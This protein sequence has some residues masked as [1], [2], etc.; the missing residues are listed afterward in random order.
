M[1]NLVTLETAFS[2]LK[3]KDK[4]LAAEISYVL[5]VK[6]H[7]NGEAKKSQF[8]A[9]ECV[10]MFDELDPE[11]KTLEDAASH[12]NVVDGVVLPEF[13]HAKVV[14]ERFQKMGISY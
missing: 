3:E 9:A 4:R 7:K 10:K 12:L 11:I 2:D 1:E 13:I 6:A 14:K 5:A 8:Y